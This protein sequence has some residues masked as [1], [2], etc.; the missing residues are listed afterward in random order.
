A[1]GN[2]FVSQTEGIEYQE[3]PPQS[4]PKSLESPGPNIQPSTN[5]AYTKF[6]QMEETQP[7]QEQTQQNKER[8]QEIPIQ[9]DT[10]LGCTKISLG[11]LMKLQPG[12]VI[13]LDKLA[14]E[15][16]DI[17]ANGKLIAKGVIVVIE[18]HFGVKII[19]LIPE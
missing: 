12:S 13:T 1:I 9:I 19:Q 3:T 8:L 10:I 15:P 7:L 5:I 16:V 17:V 4:P 11:K 2:A 18:D 14:G 6:N